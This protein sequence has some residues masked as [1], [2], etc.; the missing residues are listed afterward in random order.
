MK[1]VSWLGL[2]LVFALMLAIVATPVVLIQP[3]AAQT[4]DGVSWSY[5]L[6]QA[7]PY[8]TGLCVLLLAGALVARWSRMRW[9]GRLA[10]VALAAV[11]IGLAWFARQNHFEWMFNPFPDARFVSI[12]EA[13]DV[14]AADPVIAAS[15]GGESLAFPIRRIGYHHIINTTI[16]QEP[17]VA[18]Y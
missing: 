11:S 2:L 4:A 1:A 3:F 18:T 16:A 5:A 13:S 8:A 6:R 17:I 12:A 10:L 14:P 7:W 15:I 9:F